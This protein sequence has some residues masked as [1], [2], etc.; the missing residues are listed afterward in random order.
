M[1]HRYQGVHY[2]ASDRQGHHRL[3]LML[4]YAMWP[5]LEPGESRKGKRPLHFKN[6]ILLL[7]GCSGVQ[8]N[9]LQRVHLDEWEHISGD[10]PTTESEVT[11]L[12]NSWRAKSTSETQL[13]EARFQY[14]SQRRISL[15]MEVEVPDGP[16]LRTVVRVQSAIA[17]S[18][19]RATNLLHEHSED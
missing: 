3:S 1:Y 17:E 18:P 8:F 10:C 4:F 15:L 14:D 2:S 7:D 9:L 11:E 16:I 13:M 12:I 6:F 5:T 19:L